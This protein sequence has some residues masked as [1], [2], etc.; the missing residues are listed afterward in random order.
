MDQLPE[1]MEHIPE[2]SVAEVA[3]RLGQPDFFVF[4]N[5]GAGRYRRVEILRACRLPEP[6]RGPLLLYISIALMS[7]G[8]VRSPDGRPAGD[9]KRPAE[10]FRRGVGG[11]R[12]SAESSLAIVFTALFV[13][14]L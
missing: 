1:S 11:C 4:D 14:D 12:P 7:E 6:A 8:G 10:L 13:E 3:A 9:I 5:N 2:L